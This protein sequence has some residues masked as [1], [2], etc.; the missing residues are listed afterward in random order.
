MFGKADVDDMR[1]IAVICTGLGL[2]WPL[3]SMNLGL[4]LLAITI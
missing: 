1:S 2:H 4:K 3:L